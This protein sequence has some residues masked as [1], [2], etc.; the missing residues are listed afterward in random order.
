[1][2]ITVLGATGMAGTAV[3][4]EALRRGHKVTAVSRRRRHQSGAHLTS[5]LLDVTDVEGV[6]GLLEDSDAAV[7]ALRPPAGHESDLVRLTTAVLDAASRSRTPLLFIGGAAPLSSPTDPSILAIDD[8]TIVP[9]AWRDVAQASLD[10]FRVCQAH[11]YE[12]WVYLSPPAIFGPGDV[13]G[14]YRRG[15]T[16]LL[17]D[18]HG[19]SRISP[20]D[21]ALAVVDELEHPGGEQHV[22]VIASA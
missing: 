15:T 9:P 6:A 4:N 7:V 22:T 20:E 13:T 19:A 2:R 16:T 1:M 17:R 14:A 11:S 10:Q 21:L 8:P 12:G 3:V 18:A 5:C